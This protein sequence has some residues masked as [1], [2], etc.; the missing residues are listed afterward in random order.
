MPN[1]PLVPMT[2]EY[3][4]VKEWKIKNP[5][6]VRQQRLRYRM[7]VKADPIR[8]QR[9]QMHCNNSNIKHASKRRSASRN[10]HHADPIRARARKLRNRYGIT[11]ED[12]NDRLT[13]QNG[14]CAICKTR[15]ASC[16]DHCHATGVVRGLLCRHCNQLLG[17]AFDDIATLNAAIKYL[18]A[19]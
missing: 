3:Q 5:D 16:V 9:H 11:I 13:A 14:L 1:V 2:W 12:F 6:K 8:T 19:V 17:M 18:E 4:R 15:P 10:Y 7:K